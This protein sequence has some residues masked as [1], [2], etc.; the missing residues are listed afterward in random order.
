MSNCWLVKFVNKVFVVF[1]FVFVKEYCEVV[2]NL[3]RVSVVN[4]IVK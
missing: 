4:V 1:L 2:G 3:V